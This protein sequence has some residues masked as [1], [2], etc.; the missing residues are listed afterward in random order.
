MTLTVFHDWLKQYLD[1]YDTNLYKFI[2]IYTVG[3]PLLTL[4]GQMAAHDEVSYKQQGVFWNDKLMVPLPKYHALVTTKTQFGV[5]SRVGRLQ[6]FCLDDYRSPS[7]P[8]KYNETLV[9]SCN[10]LGFEERIP[11]ARAPAVNV[12]PHQLQI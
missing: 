9:A 6:P 4:P 8:P 3:V 10:P 2:E 7:N 1:W 11:V 5:R 12:P